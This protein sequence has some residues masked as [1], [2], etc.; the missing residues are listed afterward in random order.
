[1]IQH[2]PGPWKA[3]SC[4]QVP[5]RGAIY[6]EG[7]GGW[8]TDPIASTY[9]T[10]DRDTNEANARLIAAA[11]CLLAASRDAVQAIS[12][13]MDT[14]PGIVTGGLDDAVLGLNAAIAKAEGRTP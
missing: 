4:R 10:D 9:E 3:D 13:L 11:P 2:T 12:D 7:P 6:V 8:D 14:L 1:M 5:E